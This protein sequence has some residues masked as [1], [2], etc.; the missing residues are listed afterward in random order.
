VILGR[1]P[2]WQD[3]LADDKPMRPDIDL[4]QGSTS[5]RI[6][7]FISRLIYRDIRRSRRN[8]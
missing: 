1:V 3:N 8:G 2:A 5:G 7:F 6:G 4:L